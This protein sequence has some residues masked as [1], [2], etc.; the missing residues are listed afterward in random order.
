MKKRPGLW[1]PAAMIWACYLVLAVG[2][3][4][5]QAI[6]LVGYADL[7]GKAAGFAEIL[8]ELK[9]LGFHIAFLHPANPVKPGGI[10]IDMACGAGANPAA[11][12]VDPRDVIVYGGV[13]A[14][15]AA[16]YGYNMLHSGVLDIG[17]F[18][19]TLIHLLFCSN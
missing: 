6:Q 9:K 18:R 12:A 11:I 1:G 3:V 17:H 7:T 14:G 19:H 10:H 5:D 13:A 8:G 15:R 4:Q 2:D 16:G